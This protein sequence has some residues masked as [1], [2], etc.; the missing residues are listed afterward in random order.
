MKLFYFKL[1]FDLNYH[2]NFLARVKF[3]PCGLCELKTIYALVTHSM[4]QNI[5]CV[6]IYSYCAIPLLEIIN[7]VIELNDCT[8]YPW[9]EDPRV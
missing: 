2:Y 1:F 5:N 7:H 8:K 9:T 6:Q 4:I 3:R